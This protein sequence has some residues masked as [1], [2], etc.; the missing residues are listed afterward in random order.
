MGDFNM[1]DCGKKVRYEQFGFGKPQKREPTHYEEHLGEEVCVHSNGNSFYGILSD[2]DIQKG[3][4]N[5]NY[6]ITTDPRIRK[7]KKADNNLAI[8]LRH[9]III[10]LLWKGCLDNFLKEQTFEDQQLQQPKIFTFE[11]SPYF[12]WEKFL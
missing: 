4:L 5:L 7:F 10:R 2:V 8:P 12:P 9:E 3:L 6:H 1:E 11:N